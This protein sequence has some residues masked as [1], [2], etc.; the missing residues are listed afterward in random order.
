MNMTRSLASIA[1]LLLGASAAP[2]LAEGDSGTRRALIF[3]G[4]P[5]DAEHREQYAETVSKLAGSL[6]QELGFEEL[7]VLFGTEEMLSDGEPVPESVDGPCTQESIRAAAAEVREALHPDDTLWVVLIG[8]A[9]LDGRYSWF[10]IAGSDLHQE[11]LADSFRDL[12]CR[13]QVFWITTPAS[14]F[15]A[16]TLAHEGRVVITATEADREINETIFPHVLAGVLTQP[17]PDLDADADEAIT[18]LD[19][20]L[21]VAR[22]VARQYLEENALPTEHAQLED[23]GD[24]RGTEIQIDYLPEELG[25]R[26]SGPPQAARAENLDGARAAKI[27]IPLKPGE[28]LAPEESRETT[29]T[30]Q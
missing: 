25:G 4:H 21:A 12:K 22:G 30:E 14:G 18:L 3:C 9:H 15:Y 26:A 24:G 19:L 16:R 2:V 8:H 5:G 1:L 27:A 6:A 10:N 20:Y 28:P 29:E 13:E 7:T 17:P 11:Q 23:N